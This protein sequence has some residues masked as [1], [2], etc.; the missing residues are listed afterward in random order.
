MSVSNRALAKA[1]GRVTA[2]FK[3]RKG[4]G[5]GAGTAVKRK[6]V[7]APVKQV[8]RKLATGGLPGYMTN[9]RK[10]DPALLKLARHKNS[11]AKRKKK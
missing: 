1:G 6:K 4:T 11:E 3:K 9:G 5:K 8:T 2:E 10:P 7:K